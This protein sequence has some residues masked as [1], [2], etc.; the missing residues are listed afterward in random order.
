[1]N[2]QEYIDILQI[3]C[4]SEDPRVRGEAASRLSAI[5]QSQ[6]REFELERQLARKRGE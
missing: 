3:L 6:Q 5:Q 2:N 1:M 4:K